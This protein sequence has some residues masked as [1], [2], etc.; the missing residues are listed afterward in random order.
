MEGK[1]T[2]FYDHGSPH[3]V[4]H[5]ENGLLEGAVQVYTETGEL[6][7]ELHYQKGLRHGVERL[8]NTRGELTMEC[9]YD[10]GIPI[11]QAHQWASNG[12]LIKEV[13]FHSFPEDFD[14][15]IWNVEGNIVQSY[16]HGIEDFTDI[17]QQTQLKADKLEVEIQSIYKQLHE[18]E[19]LEKF[20]EAQKINP[21]IAED[22]A[23]L[24]P[25]KEEFEDLKRQLIE[26]MQNN[27]KKAEN[28][29]TKKISKEK[30]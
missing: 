18:P 28:E 14:L 13:K 11:G 12:Q 30:P 29:R 4:L 24:Q 23:A 17:Y 5:Y 7:R 19:F 1:Q 2:Y 26:K 3:V 6:L 16:Q 15:K 20:A 8:W 21:Q 25:L 27:L 9:Q 22:F 10:K